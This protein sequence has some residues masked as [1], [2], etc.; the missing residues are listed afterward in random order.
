MTNQTIVLAILVFV[1]L[2][3]FQMW[4][5]GKQAQR[6]M[7]AVRSVRVQGRTAIGTAGGRVG[8]RVYAAVA[9]DAADRVVDATQLAGKTVFAGPQALP[10]IA[11]WELEQL[12]DPA[13]GPYGD[14]KLGAAVADAATHLLAPPVEDDADEPATSDEGV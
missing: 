2:W 9:V 1:A 8:G 10:E 5:G 12:L 14:T 6:F 7:R 3:A 13:A 4:M 11:G